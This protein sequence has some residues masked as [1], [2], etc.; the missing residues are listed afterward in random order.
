MY[1]Q[2]SANSHI[3]YKQNANPNLQPL[4]RKPFQLVQLNTYQVQNSNLRQAQ[5]NTSQSPHLSKNIMSQTVSEEKPQKMKWGPPTWFALHTLAEKVKEEAFPRIRKELFEMI[6]KI[7][8]NLPCPNCAN[9]ATQYMQ[10]INVATIQTKKQLKDMLYQFHNSVN[11]KKGY[12]LFSYEELN[13]KYALSNTSNIL[14]H[15]MQHFEQS[16]SSRVSPNNFHRT[17]AIAI[18]KKWLAENI[19]CFDP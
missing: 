11:A 5:M 2:F 13:E 10:S 15:F 4:S 3:I 7:C 14:K 18:L 9:H 19:Q 1:L 16:Y 12:P 17:R 8:N 6:F